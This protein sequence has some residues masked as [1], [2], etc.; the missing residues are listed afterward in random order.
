MTDREPARPRQQ[1]DGV[2]GPLTRG[3]PLRP[4]RVVAVDHKQRD[5]R[6][7]GQR[8]RRQPGDQ[9]QGAATSCGDGPCQASLAAQTE[10]V[11][12]SLGQLA[13]AGGLPAVHPL[14]AQ[15]DSESSH[16]FVTVA[17]DL[18]DKQQGN[19]KKDSTDA[20][21]PTAKKHH[22]QYDDGIQAD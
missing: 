3:P 1:D 20:P 9:H 7:S 22:D 10:Q 17:D 12:E 21:A 13:E 19:R 18:Q 11:W 8:D 6:R 14:A 15:E 2:D 16:R 4:P 5:G